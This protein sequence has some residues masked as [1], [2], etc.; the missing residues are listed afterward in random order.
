MVNEFGRGAESAEAGVDK[1]RMRVFREGV[2]YRSKDRA[3]GTGV[4]PLN[5]EAMKDYLNFREE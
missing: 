5:V 2:Y 4:A 3:K 1:D